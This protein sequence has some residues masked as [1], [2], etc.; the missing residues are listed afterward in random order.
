MPA[1]GDTSNGINMSLVQHADVVF[2]GGAFILIL[3]AIGA[4]CLCRSGMCLQWVPGPR[5]MGQKAGN[6]TNGPCVKCVTV[7]SGVTS[8]AGFVAD[9]KYFY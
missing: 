9:Q 2:S 3:V 6:G 5:F 1:P 8:H 4:F 7:S